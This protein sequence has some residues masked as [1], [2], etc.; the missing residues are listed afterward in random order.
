MQ[1]FDLL[2]EDISLARVLENGVHIREY[3]LPFI[4]HIECIINMLMFAF[5]AKQQLVLLA[6]GCSWHILREKSTE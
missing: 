6:K 5:W 4:L 1:Y 2:N 3:T